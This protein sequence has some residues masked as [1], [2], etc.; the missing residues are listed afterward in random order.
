[1]KTQYQTF[2]QLED[3]VKAAH[4]QQKDV[5]ADTRQ[6]RLMPHDGKTPTLAVQNNGEYGVNEYAHRQIGSRLGIPAVYYDRMLRDEPSL[7]AAN[8]N[9]WFNHKP[10]RRMVRMQ[11]GKVRAFLSDRYQRLDNFPIMRKVLLP[12]LKEH[13]GNLVFHS[14][15]LTE[16][17]MYLKAVLPSVRSEVNVGE[18]VEAGIEFR[19]GEIGNSRFEAWPFMYE[20]TCKN[21]ARFETGGFKKMHVGARAEVSDEVYEMLSDETLRLDDAA[22]MAKVKDMINATLT[23]RSFDKLV[24]RAR[25]AKKDRITGNPAQAIQVLGDSFGMSDD[26]KGSVLRHLIEGGDLSKWGVSRAVTRAAQ[27]LESYDRSDDFEGFGGQIIELPKTEW[28][29]LAEAA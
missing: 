24:D 10:E 1:M 15:A 11:A 22:F 2:E 12:A 25:E 23:Q 9:T 29:R 7:L 4:A 17:R 13:A 6:L 16:S 8:V 21:G 28:S 5:I 3:A 27:D 26:E 18:I 20:L 19:N 14:L